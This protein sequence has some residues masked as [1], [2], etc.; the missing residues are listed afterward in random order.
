MPTTQRVHGTKI[1]TPADGAE[2]IAAFRSIVA[3][4]QFAKIDGVLVDLFSANYV[5][6]VF[7]ALS[8]ANQTKYAAMPAPRMVQVAFQLTKKG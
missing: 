4:R 1:H 2:R 8:P 5:V 3:E 7:D 6:Q